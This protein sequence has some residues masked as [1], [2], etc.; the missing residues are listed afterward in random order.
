MKL[1][2]IDLLKCI[3]CEGTIELSAI[4]P[5]KSEGEIIEFGVLFCKDC[6]S[7]YPIIKGVGVFFNKEIIGHYLNDYEKKICNELGIAY[8]TNKKNLDLIQQKQLEVSEN[9]SYQWNVSSNIK[10]EDFNKKGF[11]SEEHFYKFIPID[12]DDIKGKNIIIW[13]GGNGREAFHIIKYNPK[14]LTVNEIGDEIYGIRE[15]LN[16][17]D[18][19][20]LIRCDMQQ[21]P[22]KQGIADFSICDHALQHVSD[23]KKGFKMIVDV[24]KNNGMLA[25]NVY[26]YENNFLMT[27]IIEPLKVILHKLPLRLLEKIALIPAVF[28]YLLIHLFY[29]PLGKIFSEQVCKKIPLFEHMIFW[30]KTSFKCNRTACFDLIHAPISYHF[31]KRELIAMAEDNGVIIQKLEN[32]HG[33]TWSLVAKVFR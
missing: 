12:I 13:C 20:M 4:H 24:L 5:K 29:V 2:H 14:V 3:E 6:G 26:S 27:H 32:I 16:N 19:L 9:W 1:S 17:P 23:H 25:I 33:T 10:K 22:I 30:S 8:E 18:N 7:L 11:I 21:N 31:K 15:L 28:I